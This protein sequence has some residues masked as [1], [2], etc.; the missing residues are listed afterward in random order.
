LLEE[1]RAAGQASEEGFYLLMYLYCLNN[2]VAE[3]ESRAA[4]HAAELP[5]DKKRDDFWRAL[6]A[7]FGFRPPPVR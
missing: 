7:E 6:Q 1:L 3:A 2:Q 4:A 5:P